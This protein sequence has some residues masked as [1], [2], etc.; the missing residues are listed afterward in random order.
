[1]ADELI[2]ERLLELGDGLEIWRIAPMRL[3]EQDRNARVMSPQQFAAL[4]RNIAKRKALESLPLVHKVGDEFFIISGHHRVRAAIQAEL[5]ALLVLV[6]TRPL[7]RSEVVAKQLSHNAIA[8]H[9]DPAMLRQLLA[10]IQDIDALVE[11]AVDKAAIEKLTAVKVTVPDV[12]VD[13]DWKTLI[14]TFLPTQVEDLEALCDQ[15]KGH[16]VIGVVDA[17]IY[18][19]FVTAMRKLGKADNI[20]SIG[21]LVYRMMQI[22]EEYLAAQQPASTEGGTT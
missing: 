1:M 21:A 19:R 2:C 6:E 17:A 4:V 7:T 11:S 9:D 3:R 15:V 8:G 18:E 13:Y 14:F 5:P 10:E 16:D 12:K 20:R 22:T